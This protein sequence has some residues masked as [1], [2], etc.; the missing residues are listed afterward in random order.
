MKSDSKKPVIFACAGCSAAGRLAYDLAQE[1][2]RRQ[3][4]EMSCLAGL[5][6]QL[7]LFTRQIASRPVWLIDG[8]EIQCGR[9]I[10]ERQDRPIDRHIRL[11][12]YGVR[13][14]TG[15][16]PGADLQAL[17]DGLIGLSPSEPDPRSSPK[18]DPELSEK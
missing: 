13:K 12:E 17:A 16:P 3:V 11:D 7:P 4:A 6:A 5:A 10:F 18:L 8:C 2:D 9:A 14:K 1:F 15:L